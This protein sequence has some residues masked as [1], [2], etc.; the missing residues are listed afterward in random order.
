VRAVRIRLLGSFEA[1]DADGGPLSLPTRKTEALL[2]RLA[3]RPGERIARAHLA[4]LLWPDRPDEQG[5]AS[6]RQAL[7]AIRAALEAA[8]VEGPTSGRDVVALP[9]VGVEVDVADVEAE[10]ARREPDPTRLAAAC[11][12]PLL[13]G[14][15]PVEGPFD[16]WVEEERA[17]LGRRLLGQ[18]GS[19]LARC[20]DGD[21][22]MTLALA[23]AA[24]AV[25]AA[26]EPAYRARMALLARRGERAAALREYDRC[27]SALARALGATPGASTEA[28]RRELAGAAAR[29]DGAAERSSQAP[30]LAI[31]PFDVLTG[32]TRLELLA[33]GLYE[34]LVGTLSR[35]RA[36]RVLARESVER[37]APPSTDGVEAG[38]ALGAGYSLA[39]AVR[40]SSGRMR[41]SLR[42]VE[43]ST[44]RQ[45]W[46]DRL[47]V[48]VEGGFEA[49]DRITRAVAAALALHIDAA[50]LEGALRRPPE[51][52]EA[53]ECWVRGM[54]S[55][56]GGTAEAD[57]TARRLFE[58]AVE[59]SP[60]FARA[61]SGLSLSW[62]NDWSCS[63]WQRWDETERQAYRHALEATR[64]DPH[65]HVTHCILGRILL[66]RREFDRGIEHLRRA[67]ALNPN[68]ADVLVHACLG[69]AYFGEPQRALELER[70]ALAIHPFHPE[71]YLAYF[72]GGR[73]VAR[74]A[75]E[76][77]TRFE[78]VA[79]L[80]VDARAF[81]AAA[82][83]A[84]GELDTARLQARAFRE[85]FAQRIAYGKPF[86][87]EDPVRWILRVNP[88]RRDEDRDY[89]LD[90][91]AR[92][93]L[94]LP[95]ERSA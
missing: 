25:D 23:D 30:S 63:A 76:A 39:T 34:D 58:R 17:A 27:R 47:D 18:L 37:F 66:Y 64:L 87:P 32:D 70:E 46:A 31:L 51:R 78:R 91:L 89:L 16:D 43:T 79:D 13:A 92:A 38:R 72:A 71:W 7:T 84:L 14:F 94:P 35:F 85:R 28:L 60:G 41:V 21:D 29:P 56:R 36:L 75:E 68:D 49:Q 24:L 11:R 12:G 4:G 22:A 50:E 80:T 26:F 65:D 83:A 81:I 61:H 9:P 53:Y 1:V 54:H 59:L 6:L 10:L 42:L 40:A 69:H 8:G 44:S 86:A 33:R 19:A 52:L 55:L 57:A 77:R 20:A 73:F 88:L 62:F 45:V 2:A 67:V 95:P 15:P 90:H 93:G 5:R 48:E 3:R 82:S 74:Q